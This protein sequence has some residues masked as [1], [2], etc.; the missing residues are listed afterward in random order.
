MSVK[1]ENLEKNLAKLTVEVPVEKLEESIDQVYRKAKN[2]ITLPGFRKGKAPRKMIE[3][4][5]GADVFLEDAVNE[6]IPV[7]YEEACGECELEIVSQPEIEYEQVEAGKPVIF[8]ATVAT[9]PEVTLGEY[10][11]LEVESKPVEVTEEEILAELKKEQEKNAT[12]KTVDDRA[13]ED[14]DIIELAFE[15]FVDGAPFEGGKSDNYPLTIGSHSFIPGFEEQLIGAVIGEEKNVDVTFP[16][17]YHAKELAGKPAVFKCTVHTIKV[18][19]LPELDDEFASEVSDFETL[20]EYKEDVKKKLT[21][22]KEKEA[23]IAKE[24]AL[25]DKIIE[26]SQMEVPELMITSQARSMVSEFGQRLQSQGLNLQQY[27][28]YTGQTEAQMIDQMKEQA[29]K[30]IQTRLVMEAIVAAES[31]VATEEDVEEEI[32]KMAEAYGMDVE[33]VKT[34]MDEEQKEQMKMNIAVQKAI[35]MVYA[36]AK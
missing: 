13:V 3:K 12:M 27:M 11:G 28:Q 21:E 30:R 7:A 20:D 5:Y 9:R 19:E 22:N 4:Y 24:D 18:K 10:K 29:L 32:K 26:N 31:L 16:E 34:Y 15:G 25:V 23:K 1:V 17:E 6:L 35:D 8:T 33:Q 2:Q 14:G 36:A